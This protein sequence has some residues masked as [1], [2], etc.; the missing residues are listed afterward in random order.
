M[1]RVA[2]Q[3]QLVMLDH[4]LSAKLTADRTLYGSLYGVA[5]G[6]HGH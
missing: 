5:R 6:G 3:R 4:P 2:G 1:P